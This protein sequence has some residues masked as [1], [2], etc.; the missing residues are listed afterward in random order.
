M[1]K[2]LLIAVMLA[3]VATLMLL[4]TVIPVAA[5]NG[6]PSASDFLSNFQSIADGWKLI[7]LSVLVFA[8]LGLGVIN[9]A[10]NKELLL[11]RLWDISRKRIIPGLVGYYALCFT[12]AINN[13]LA[14]LATG[15]FAVFTAVLVGDVLANLK[16]LGVP[17]PLPDSLTNFLTGTSSSSSPPTQPPD[18]TPPAAP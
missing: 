12:G 2:K 11:R 14:G 6:E 3:V 5:S 8:V 7:T 15:A 10:L 18:E 1:K 4:M 17:F 16:E 9:A 13:D